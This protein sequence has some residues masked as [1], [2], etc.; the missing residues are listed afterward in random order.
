MLELFDLKGRVAMVT[1]GSSGIG[2]ALAHALAGAGANVV[3]V[4][5]RE[6]ELQN[7]AAQI[8][9]THERVRYVVGDL[10]HREQLNAVCASCA[11]HFGPPDV[12][13]NAAGINLREPPQDISIESWDLT[14]N[15]NLAAPF[16]I[17]RELVG[18]MCERQYGRIINIASLQ[19]ER[20]FPNGLPYGASKGGVCQLTRAMAEAWGADGIT[21]NAIAP[22]FFPT[23]L[24]R[25]VFDD[26][27]TRDKLAAQTACGRNGHL[28]DL[29]GSVIFLASQ[30]SAYVT[31]QTLFV[32]GGFTAK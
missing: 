1:G 15:L 8:D 28:S 29:H 16:F 11:A 31:G 23:D 2:A 19:S 17:A 10:S 7:T 24:T 4:A 6:A 27:E 26:H 18:S 25:A 14:L 30:A 3:L 21:A 20:A 13:V 22:G 12:L 32:D 9:P 5:R